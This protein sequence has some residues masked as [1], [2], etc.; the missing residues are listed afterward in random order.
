[1]TKKYRVVFLGLLKGPDDFKQAMAGFGV[2]P[3][4]AETIIENAPM[5]LKGEMTLGKARQYAEAVQSAGGRVNI[6]E[7]GFF[8]EPERV[9]RRTDIKSLNHF[10]M[11]AQCG[12]KQPK[13]EVCEKCGSPLAG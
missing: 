9:N 4:T 11:C 2:P 3:A 8:Q 6:Q 7:C 10:T 1:M 13:A 12:H 5:I